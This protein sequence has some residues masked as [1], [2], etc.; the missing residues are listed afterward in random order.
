MAHSAFSNYMTAISGNSG[1]WKSE[2]DFTE[3]SQRA[4]LLYFGGKNNTSGKGAVWEVK[5]VS[6]RKEPKHSMAIAQLL[7]YVISAN[8]PKYNEGLAFSTGS[9]GGPMPFEGTLTL[10]QGNY[11][12]N[13]FITDPKEGLI[14]Y[15]YSL[16]PDKQPPST[17]PVGIKKPVE[18]P[19][20]GSRV[21]DLPRVPELSP[22]A[23]VA[24]FATTVG[25]GLLMLLDKAA[26][27]VC[28]II[29]LDP[30]MVDP[31][32]YNN[33]QMQQF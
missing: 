4:D 9:N 23:K 17:V 6:Y 20:T 8:Q 27:R 12:F 21:I 30:G 5:P 26:S 32:Y 25:L 11:T 2:M 15:T 18:V 29:I 7:G 28:P 16:S 24:A 13:Y 1:N 31:T 19:N 10:K 14:Y 3:Y 33:P 22:G